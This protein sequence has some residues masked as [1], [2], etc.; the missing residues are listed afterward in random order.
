[1]LINLKHVAA[2][3]YLCIDVYLNKALHDCQQGTRQQEPC[4]ISFIL[5]SGSAQLVI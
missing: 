4:K 1:M 3:C 5:S 2:K